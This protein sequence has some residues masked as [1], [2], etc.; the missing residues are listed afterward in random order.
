MNMFTSYKI[1]LCQLNAYITHIRHHTQCH[2]MY[3]TNAFQISTKLGASADPLSPANTA[4]TFINICAF[5]FDF[6]LRISN[7]KLSR[8]TLAGEWCG[9]VLRSWLI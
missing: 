2:I 5:Y 6:P 9:Y 7:Q 3:E 4:K 8:S 1:V